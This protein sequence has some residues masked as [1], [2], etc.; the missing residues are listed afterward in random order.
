MSDPTAAGLRTGALILPSRPATELAALAEHAEALGYDDFWI[1]D[2]RFL[3]EVYG[4]LALCAL[5]TTRI[6]LGPC[7]TDPY[8]R[9]PALTTMAIATLDELSARRAVLG[10]GAGGTGF[11]ALGIAGGRSAVAMRE[12]I[13]L[14]RRLLIGESVMVRGEHVRFHDGELGFLPLRRRIPVYVASQRPSGCRLAGAVGDGAIMH[15]AVAD[16]LLRFF[17]DTVAE[18]ARRAA[19]SAAAIDLVARVDVCIDD[20][21][22]AARDALRGSVARALAAQRRDFFSFATAGLPVPATLGDKVRALE[23]GDATLDALAPEVPDE[24]V[25]GVALAGPPDRVA[26]QLIRMVRGGITNVLVHPIATAAGVETTLERFQREVM[27]RVR[28]ALGDVT[29]GARP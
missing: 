1:A 10:I 18:G 12:A 17:R 20:D 9:H 7:V 29:S 5:R 13:D 14:V 11:Q 27:P 28:A 23:D 3:R 25:D 16:P 2:A 19:R 4:C 24:L 8:S 22:D 26:G 21:H 15:G 6:R